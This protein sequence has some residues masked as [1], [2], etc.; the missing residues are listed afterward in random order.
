MTSMWVLQKIF[1]KET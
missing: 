1:H